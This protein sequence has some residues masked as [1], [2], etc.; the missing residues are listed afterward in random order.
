MQRHALVLLTAALAAC[1][2]DEFDWGGAKNEVCGV[3]WEMRITDG[4]P[5]ANRIRPEI[6]HVEAERRGWVSW[7]ASYQGDAIEP[8]ERDLRIEANYF[9]Q[10]NV[11]ALPRGDEAF[12]FRM[13]G[14]C[15]Y[16]TGDS[17]NRDTPLRTYVCQLEGHFEDDA[18]DV[19]L[20]L[21]EVDFCE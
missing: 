8:I 5:G 10:Q 7:T 12:E 1:G 15:V 11:F 13:E 2:L 21:R 9:P 18:Y 4:P 3:E 19:E 14:P 16:Q 20:T 17:R 6:T